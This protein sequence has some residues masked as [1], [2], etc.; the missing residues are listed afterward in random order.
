MDLFKDFFTHYGVLYPLATLSKN[1]P[2]NL[3][4]TP[5]LVEAS[6]PRVSEL[7]FKLA[8]SITKNVQEV[9]SDTRKIIH[10]AAVFANNFANHMAH[11]G[12]QIL[13]EQG[14][15]QKLLDPILEETISKIR[16]MG[17]KGAQTGP[18]LRNDLDTMQKHVELLKHHP[19]WE[20]LY[21]FISRDIGRTRDTSDLK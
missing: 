4:K 18:A 14:L 7:I 15:D 3:E 16:T 5:F 13:H 6:S 2:A 17:A 19:E 9:D 21:T 8:G 11:I 1:Q 20:K 12:Q 10:M